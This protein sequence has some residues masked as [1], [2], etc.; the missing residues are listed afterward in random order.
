MLFNNS[1][2]TRLPNQIFLTFVTINIQ[3][4]EYVQELKLK[5]NTSYY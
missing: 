1:I 3:K 4:I 5:H 2:N